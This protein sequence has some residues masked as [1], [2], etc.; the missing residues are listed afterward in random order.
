MNNENTDISWGRKNEFL[1]VVIL[2][3]MAGLLAKLPQITGIDPEQFYSKNIPFIVFP[4][5][6][7]YFVWKQEQAMNKLIIPFILM[8]ILVVYINFLPFNSS[9]DSILLAY[10]HLPIFLW[11]LLGSIYIGGDF[12]NLE[13][14]ISFLRYNADFL[15]MTALILISGAL[16]SALTMGL[17]SLIDLDIRQFYGE[18][19]VIF[20]VSAVPVVSTFLVQSNPKLVSKISPII[21]KIFTPIVSLM[22]FFF[23]LA[24]IIKGKYP[25]NDRNALMVFNALLIGV[26]ALII[27]SITEVSKDSKR[28]INGIL[29]FCLSLLTILINCIALFAIT[30]RIGEFGITPNRVAV[31]GA[32]MLIMFHLVIVTFRL[33]TLVKRAAGIEAVEKS[34]V[35]YFPLYLAWALFVI[36]FFPFVFA[37]K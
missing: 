17:F 6:I 27:F 3:L 1:L 13:K 14:R 20:G 15:V 28:G 7:V 23:L 21:A 30:F 11:G 24:V 16:F 31:I 32:N 9:R 2:S 34:I 26:M 4:F 12:K 36:L 37:F 33:F 22:L 5:L 35:S 19:I 10:I 29:L 8:L 18:Y 25:T